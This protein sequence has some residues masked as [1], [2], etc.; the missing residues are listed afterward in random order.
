LSPSPLLDKESGRPI[1]PAELAAAFLGSS[2]RDGNRAADG[3]QCHYL[4]ERKIS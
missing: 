2:G 1:A 3:G 4:P